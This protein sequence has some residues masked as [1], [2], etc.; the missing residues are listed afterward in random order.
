[1][2]SVSNLSAGYDGTPVLE[3]ID[4]SVGAGEVVAVLGSNGAGKST[5]LKSIS[6]LL[7]ASCGS[8]SLDDANIVGISPRQIVCMGVTHVPEGRRIFPGLSVSE[9]LLMG[10]FTVRDKIKLNANLAMVFE[11]FPR[12]AERR[13]QIG[14]TLSGGEQQMLSIARALMSSPRFLLL[15]EPSMGLAPVIVERLFELTQDLA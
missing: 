4:L 13:S 11:L 1:M 3:A 9:N 8:I 5:L 10:G 14:T 6:G 15:D 7:R 12:L 2:L